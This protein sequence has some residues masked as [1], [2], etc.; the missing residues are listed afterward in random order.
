MTL[1]TV[2]EEWPFTNVEPSANWRPGQK[3]RTRKSV[4]HTISGA[5]S[6]LR[7]AAK[8]EDFDLPDL[9]VLR[10]MRADLDEAEQR[11]VDNLKESHGWTAVADAAGVTRS[12]AIRKWAKR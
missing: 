4:K 10:S 8:R 6:M 7:S 2:A 9:A 11:A 12:Y 3:A 5:K 1:Q